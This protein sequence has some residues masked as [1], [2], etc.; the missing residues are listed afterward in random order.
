MLELRNFIKKY[1]TK[2]SSDGQLLHKIDNGRI[3]LSKALQDCIVSLMKGNK[4]FML[5]DEQIVVYDMCLKTM[6]Q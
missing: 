3:R 6:N 4:E 1:I 5:L 2:K